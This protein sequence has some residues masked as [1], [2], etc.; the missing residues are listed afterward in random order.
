MA[1]I[2]G[3]NTRFGYTLDLTR[4]QGMQTVVLEADQMK[5]RF[6]S[7]NGSVARTSGGR[8]PVA[9]SIQWHGPVMANACFADIPAGLK[10]LRRP[11]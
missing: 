2:G 11:I 7:R 3:G 6:S 8:V 4:E 9:K 5:W 10:M 1:V